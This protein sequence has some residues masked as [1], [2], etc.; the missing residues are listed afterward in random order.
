MNLAVNLVLGYRLTAKER[1]AHYELLNGREMARIQSQNALASWCLIAVLLLA[2]YTAWIGREI[3]LACVFLVSLSWP[4]RAVLDNR[5]NTQAAL[6]QATAAG[7]DRVVR[8]EVGDTGL[9][10]TVE[11]IVSFAPWS[12][13]RGFTVFQETL[14]IRLAAGLWAIVPFTKNEPESASTAALIGELRRRGVPEEKS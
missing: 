2:I 9:R 13:V 12:G 3:F 1:L 5:R 7:P 11:D 6:E 14:F 4:V 8:L 10:E